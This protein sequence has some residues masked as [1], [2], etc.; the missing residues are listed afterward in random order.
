MDLYALPPEEFTAARD[1]EVKAARRSGDRG[2]AAVLAALRRPTGSAYAVNALVRAD[3]ALIG[4]LVELGRQ[5][6]A[7]QSGGERDAL[8]TLGEQRRQLVEAVADRAGEAAGRPL[9]PAVRAEVTATLEA[10]LADPASGAAVLSGRLV[11]PLSYAGFGEVD[12]SGAVAGEAAPERTP[13]RPA[14]EENAAEER[15][16]QEKAVQEKAVEER[17]AE[18]AA[19][20]EVAEQRAAEQAAAAERRRRA[21]RERVEQAVRAAQDAAGALD[22]ATRE[23]ERQEQVRAARAADAQRAGEEVER[24]GEE[25]E[26]AE[27]ALAQAREGRDAAQA[28]ARRAERDLER[29]HAAVSAAQHAA[30][31]ARAAVDRLRR[32]G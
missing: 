17:A 2:R 22:D 18:E 20:Q 8:R 25:V 26:R 6:G 4:Q 14:A 23:A 32:P 12:L 10:A 7:A 28:E 21:H 11:R 13:E 31:R 1:A 30:E 5:L 15:A 16:V 3:A 29:S 24:A 27:Q 19:E 9:T